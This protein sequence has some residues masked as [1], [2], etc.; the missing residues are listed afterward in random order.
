LTVTVEAG[1]L[2]SLEGIARVAVFAPKDVAVRLTVTVQDSCL[3]RAEQ[4]V[5]VENS[6]AFV[7]VTARAPKLRLPVPAFLI[8]TVFEAVTPFLTVPTLTG[9]AD[10][11]I[12]GIPSSN[13]APTDLSAFIVI[14]HVR[15][16]P[17]HAPDHPPNVELEDGVAVRVTTVPAGNDVPAGLLVT[18]PAPV[19]VLA[20]ARVK[21]SAVNVTA[22]V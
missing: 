20:M 13:M 6:P 15:F 4:F 7:P 22:I 2:G 8:V 11:A 1:F 10:T 16:A 21:M 12:L 9:K 17:L 14:R 5:D 3:S 19:P 18:E